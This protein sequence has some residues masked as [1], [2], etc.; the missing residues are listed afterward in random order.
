MEHLTIIHQVHCNFKALRSSTKNET[1]I[2]EANLKRST[3][4]TPKLLSHEEILEK[5]SYDWVLT[6]TIPPPPVRNTRIWSIVQDGSDIRTG[7]LRSRFIATRS[8]PTN[9][10]DILVM[11]ILSI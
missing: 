8:T 9:L 3:I 10:P 2:M 11:D 7:M 5:L 4:L 6:C 1:V